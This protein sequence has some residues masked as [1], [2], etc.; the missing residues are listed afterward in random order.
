QMDINDKYDFEIQKKILK[1]K[2]EDINELYY[3]KGI[4][5]TFLNNKEKVDNHIINNLKKWNINR[6]PKVD[7]AILRL[8][9]TEFFFFNDIPIEVSVNEAVEMAKEYSDK[10]SAKFING[11]L[12]GV[13]TK[14]NLIN[15]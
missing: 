1:E 8:A 14:E 11:V 3:A 4:I 12:G 7:L 6:L 15:G 5:E 13:I 2:I 10:D 9:I